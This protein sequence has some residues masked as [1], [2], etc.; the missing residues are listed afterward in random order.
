MTTKSRQRLFPI[1]IFILGFIAAAT[2]SSTEVLTEGFL[3]S[4]S[5]VRNF[6]ITAAMFGLGS[7]I[8]LKSIKG[9]GIKPLLLG[10]VSW[11]TL[12]VLAGFGTL[13]ENRLG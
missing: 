11:I 12:L 13:I 10:S 5:E 7:G 6:L 8:R 2:L 9:L 1:P 4:I 3:D